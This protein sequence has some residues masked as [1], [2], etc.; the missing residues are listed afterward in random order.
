MTTKYL[1]RG[2]CVLTM[3]KVNFAEADVLI[4]GD[5]IVEVGPG[6][7]AR[8]AEAID[9]TN[10]IV[11]P[12]FVDAHRHAWQSL[13]RN[14]GPLGSL[15]VLGAH[16]EPDDLYAA[17]LVSLLAALDAGITSLVDWCDIA[18]TQGHLDAAL[19]AH[20]DAGIRSVFVLGKS[21]EPGEWRNQLE[22]LQ[23]RV[24]PADRV[25][26]AGSGDVAGPSATFLSDWS[27]A[28]ERGLSIHAHAGTPVTNGAEHGLLS[29]AA[30]QKELRPDVT[31]IHCTRLSDG[32]L[33][34]LASTGAKAV[35]TPQSEMATGMG[36]PPMQ[37]LIDRGIR[38]G[39]GVDSEATASGDLFAQM[40]AAI[41]LQHAVLFD[42]K[43]A[44]KAGVPRLLSTREVIRSATVDGARACRLDA[45]VGSLEPGKAADL[46]VLRTDRP[47]IFPINDPIG[48]VV[49]G[50]DTSNIDWV[51]VAGKP[52]KRAN[53]LVADVDRARQ[54]AISAHE[55]VVQNAGVLASAGGNQ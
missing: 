23:K 14:Q 46:I 34:A 36:F 50:M 7:R 6:L 51:I 10:T 21:S 25:I 30:A 52:L 15:T 44:G 18:A 53:E 32:D 22:Q 11:M 40:R 20:L 13:F 42:Q 4:E 29:D 41:S 33:S 19:Q 43:L 9:A 8:D 17:T 37:K 49:W 2:G 26:A 28:R 38:P 45:R 39:L 31:L 24:D 12:G 16:Y 3:G 35:I 55:R 54:L 48:A 1:L 5:T 47:N 27:F